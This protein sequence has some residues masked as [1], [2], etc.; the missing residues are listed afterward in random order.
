MGSTPSR[1]VFK[2]KS[3]LQSSGTE[4]RRKKIKYVAEMAEAADRGESEASPTDPRGWA[5]PPHHPRGCHGRNPH[6]EKI[7]RV[8]IGRLSRRTPEAGWPLSP[9]RERRA[10]GGAR[11]LGAHARPAWICLDPGAETPTWARNTRA[12][13]LSREEISDPRAAHRSWL[14]CQKALVITLVSYQAGSR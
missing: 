2:P 14:G 13:V 3:E 5:P 1:E 12:H 6:V 10:R 11:V 9:A 4:E 8:V 7:P